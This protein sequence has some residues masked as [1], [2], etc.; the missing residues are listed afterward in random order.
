MHVFSF[1]EFLNYGITYTLC[2]NLQH[3]LHSIQHWQKSEEQTL[4]P[5]LSRKLFYM[6]EPLL[7]CNFYLYSSEYKLVTLHFVLGFTIT[8]LSVLKLKTTEKSFLG[9]INK[10]KIIS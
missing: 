5:L 4:F 1:A 6:F 3:L 7:Y 9:L 10:Y 2:F 8:T